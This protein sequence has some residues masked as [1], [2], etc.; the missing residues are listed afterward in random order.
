M[1]R[2]VRRTGLVLALPAL[3]GVSTLAYWLA[4]HRLHGLWIMPDEAIYGERALDLWSHGELAILHG[5]GA[6]Y[7]LLY[8]VLAGAP[9]SVGRLATGY[10]S[11]KLLQA[12]TMS[13]VAV[14]VFFYG[15]RFMRPGYAL[16]A[17]ALALSSPLMLYSGLVMTEVVIY[18]IAAFALLAIARAVETA[19]LR[20]QAI[21]FAGIA[22]ALL[23]RVQSV[24]LIAV[25]AA[26]I[27][28]ERLL[29][30]ERRPLRRFWPVWC[31]LIAAAT[32]AAAAPGLVGAY[33]GTLSGHY[34]LHSA[35]ALSG[36]HFS[37][38][39]LST[40]IAPIVAL[41]L[42]IVVLARGQLP[43]PA[44]RAIVSVASC[45][46]VLVV[47]QV[48]F[49]AARYAPHLL[50]RDLAMLPPLL[51][52]VLALWLDRGAPRPRP[53]V[54]FIGLLTL[55]VLLLTPW[56]HLTNINA[57]PDTFGIV[58]LYHLGAR[59]AAW[60]VA[61]T[62]LAIL[63]ATVFLRRRYLMA[64]PMLIF[65]VLIASTAVASNDITKRVAYDQLNLV[66]VPP[67]WIDRATDGRVAYLYDHEAYWNGVW[68][69]RFWNRNV[70]DVLSVAP[71]R[72]PGPM[73]QRVVSVPPSGR[74]PIR[75]RYIVASDPH[76]FAGA[77][78]AH[79]T[80][81]G[82]DSAGLTLWR[83]TGPPR[84]ITVER[85]I[86][87]NGDMT[88]PGRVVAYD[89]AGGR[90]SLTLLPKQTGTV[91]LRLD[92]RVVQRAR[93]AGLPYWNGTIF[94]PPSRSPR[95]CHFEIDGQNLLGSTQITFVH[96]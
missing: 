24:V 39:V 93:I 51:F 4:G 32:V 43:D 96:R 47:I 38:V 94:V 62:S 49:F 58:I 46:T 25:F 14:P 13:T 59:P 44:V 28:V 78:I 12:L 67:N 86:Q 29:G 33:A 82:L 71:G 90:L 8:P 87:A 45:A 85:G 69:V 66:G 21:A 2:A 79:L 68:Q 42:L 74:L 61:A 7:G 1:V 11:L 9:L 84:L 76:A 50:G 55:A 40:G 70:T 75:E 27:I 20:H 80:Q 10:A 18:P 6:G 36:E 95:V 83:L 30:R 37:Y 53:A 88:E 57:L 3:V 22:A 91:T 56:N 92:G 5:E 41:A 89:C 26:A 54:Y 17:G 15:R 64:V 60:A 34:P 52:T 81:V 19:S 23:T 63:S 31:V 16:L 73:A 72:V 35:A 65:V 48:G 77:P